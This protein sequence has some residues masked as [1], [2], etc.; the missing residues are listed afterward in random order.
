MMVFAISLWPI[1]VAEVSRHDASPAVLTGMGLPLWIIGAIFLFNGAL[2][3]PMPGLLPEDEASMGTAFIASTAF[4]P[5]GLL[6]AFALKRMDVGDDPARR[7]A[8]ELLAIAPW[9]LVYILRIAL[10]FL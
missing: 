7:L 2:G 1:L 9:I 3:D 6:S 10:L 5:G 8:W 4:F